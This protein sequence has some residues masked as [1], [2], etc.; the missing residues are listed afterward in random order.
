MG[1]VGKFI[2]YSAIAFLAYM[3]VPS[4]IIAIGIHMP[5]PYILF[6]PVGKHLLY[7]AEN[8]SCLEQSMEVER[9]LEKHGV[10]VY[11]YS[12]YKTNSSGYVYL[13]NN[14]TL[15]GIVS[16]KVGHRWVSIDLG[17]VEIPFEP[18]VMLPIN[19]DWFFH[20]NVVTKD[21]GYY[22][23]Q[24]KIDDAVEKIVKIRPPCNVVID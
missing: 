15:E 2:K 8:Y 14:S 17:F 24:K 13:G 10:H 19:P 12:G 1:V 4:Y 21:E 20:F 16:F 18:T 7:D 9:F 5:F 6:P 22:D 3:L 23:G 11:G